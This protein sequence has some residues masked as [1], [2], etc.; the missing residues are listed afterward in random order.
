LRKL[1]DYI[2]F[3]DYDVVLSLLHSHI[4]QYQQYPYP[5][6]SLE[7]LKQEVKLKEIPKEFTVVRGKPETDWWHHPD[8]TSLG[9]LT[10]IGSW[11]ENNKNDDM[12]YHTWWLK[13]QE[14]L[15]YHD[16]PLSSKNGIWKITNRVELWKLMGSRF[17]NQ[18][19]ETFECLAV[20]VLKEPDPDLEFPLGAVTIPRE[21]LY[22]VDKELH[23]NPCHFDEL[24]AQEKI[25]GRNNVTGLL[26]ALEGLAWDEQYFVQVCIILGKLASHDH[27]D[28]W[29]NR[30]LISLVTILLPWS[31]QT[32][33]S[34]DR[35]KV[36]VQT[37][38]K[39]EPDIAWNLI[40]QLLPGKHKVSLGSHKPI[41][42]NTIPDKWK[43]DV[44]IE[45]YWEQ[46]TFYA[47]HAVYMAAQDTDR[48][49]ILIKYFNEGILSLPLFP[50]QAL[51]QLIEVLYRKQLL[52]KL[53]W[54]KL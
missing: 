31:P 4:S 9:L 35:C 3:K 44:T 25:T 41:W 2:L 23:R 8:A 26:W 36:A 54:E 40:I 45:E 7:T 15:L 24:F 50:K 53:R 18:Y 28:R 22:M 10:L 6:D 1:L 47:D 46:V 12:K 21:F 48:L 16:S 32:L 34:V 43:R 19:L 42:R 39:N 20:T 37:L 27:G 17:F 51:D 14:I 52:G 11:D 5:E 29:A 30:P 49:K 33:A 38:I 13:A